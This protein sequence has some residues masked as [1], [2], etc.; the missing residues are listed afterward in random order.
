MKKT[1][2]FTLL[3]VIGLSVSAQKIAINGYFS[4]SYSNIRVADMVEGDVNY[5]YLKMREDSL[6]SDFNFAAG[7]NFEYFIFDNFSVSLGSNYSTHNES[8]SLH[9]EIEIFDDTLR[10]TENIK[11]RFAFFNFPLSLKYYFGNNDIK[12]YIRLFGAFQY[13]NKSRMYFNNDY[14]EINNASFD[15]INFIDK[16]NGLI[17]ERHNFIV[18]GGFGITYDISDNLIF[19][20]E[21][22]IQWSL[23][24]YQRLKDME[25]VYTPCRIYSL[26]CKFG[27]SYCF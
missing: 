27:L 8:S 24:H 26:G 3:V 2:L 5:E 4:P 23:L 18:G 11:Y 12:T 25:Y 6:K 17:I 13:A 22:N 14:Y 9:K 19:Y 10:Y 7:F 20:L 15:T 1:I 16:D 21:P